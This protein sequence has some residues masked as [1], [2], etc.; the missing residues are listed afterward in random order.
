M[1]NGD[2]G[3]DNGSWEANFVAM[4][5]VEDSPSWDTPS[6]EMRLPK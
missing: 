5:A 3:W 2:E 6:T 4:I 1:E